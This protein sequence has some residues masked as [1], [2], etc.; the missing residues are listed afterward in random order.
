MKGTMHLQGHLRRSKY[1]PQQILDVI[2]LF[3][4]LWEC[5]GVSGG[6]FYEISSVLGP[7]L[8]WDTGFN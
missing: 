6:G 3:L 4:L 8:L 7:V 1:L 5:L 2:D